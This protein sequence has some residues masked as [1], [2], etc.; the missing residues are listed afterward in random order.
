ME[1]SLKFFFEK[2]VKFFICISESTPISIIFTL[3]FK[4]QNNTLS[5]KKY[6]WAGVK[7]ISKIVV[8]LL[9]LIIISDNC[10]LVSQQL[11]LLSF[12]KAIVAYVI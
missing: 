4:L 10:K 6:P 3:V 8:I 9:Q 1:V 11:Y 2:Q 7:Q 12:Y 5:K